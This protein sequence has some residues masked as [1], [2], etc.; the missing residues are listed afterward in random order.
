MLP[1]L[2]SE[3]TRE[4]GERLHV[5]V[6]ANGCTDDTADVARG[7]GVDVLETPVPSKIKALALGDRS[8]TTFPRVYVDADVVIT[9]QDVLSL[10]AALGDDVH[11]TGPVR[12]LPMAGVSTPVQLW[13]RVWQQLPGVQAELYGRGVIAVDEA[14]HERLRDW[15][16]VMSDDLHVAMAFA[17]SERSVVG[18]AVAVIHPPKTYRDLLR[19][20][21]RALTG[22]ARLLQQH[23]PPVVRPAG[24]S[25]RYLAGLVRRRPKQLP[26]VAVFVA[27]AA[28]AQLRSRRAVRRGDTRWLRDE[29][30]R[31]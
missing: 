18:D 22:N 19:R 24:G 4:P 8:L 1:R 21:V 9:A 16:E 13:Y 31:E 27:T 29:S 17:P 5:V 14:G 28:V 26:A 10:A 30:S 23:D 12:N 7:F 3:L 25:P 15:P 6:V 20:R 11:A 2:L